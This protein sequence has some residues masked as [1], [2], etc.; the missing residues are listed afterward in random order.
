[1]SNRYRALADGNKAWQVNLN[2]IPYKVKVESA[3]GMRNL[4]AHL[5]D[6]TPKIAG[7]NI[8]ENARVLTCELTF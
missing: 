3:V 7:V 1:M 8:F 5:C 2:G 6:I 4:A